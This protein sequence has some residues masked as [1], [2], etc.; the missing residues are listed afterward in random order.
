M[1]HLFPVLV[2][3]PLSHVVSRVY[4]VDLFV[5]QIMPAHRSAEVGTEHLM[6][7]KVCLSLARNEQN[8]IGS[9]TDLPP[10]KRVREND[11][12][13]VA[14]E[15]LSSQPVGAFFLMRHTRSATALGLRCVRP[16]GRRGCSHFWSS[17]EPELRSKHPPKST[18][19][20]TRSK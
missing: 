11:G 1:T 18:L 17:I 4:L 9:G 10:A 16:S 2:C 7:L 12:N 15:Q 20:E 5:F 14:V 8:L 13:A 3:E 6:R 19:G